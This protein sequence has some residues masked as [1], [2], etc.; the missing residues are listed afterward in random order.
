M[1]FQQT[2]VQQK[3]LRIKEGTTMAD[4]TDVTEKVCDDLIKEVLSF[5]NVRSLFSACKVNNR[6]HKLTNQLMMH[7]IPSN[8][9]KNSYNTL[10]QIGKHSNQLKQ[11]SRETR[12]YKN[13]P[14][15]VQ[16]TNNYHKYFKKLMNYHTKII[17]LQILIIDESAYQIID[18]NDSEWEDDW[19]PTWCH[20]R[21]KICGSVVPKHDCNDSGCECC[22]YFTS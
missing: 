16:F 15:L 3:T 19:D 4:T 5:L 12:F 6:W 1:K 14:K 21:C 18:E 20:V 13:G 10:K 8:Q 22:L 11:L 17:K 7:V 9:L 2:F